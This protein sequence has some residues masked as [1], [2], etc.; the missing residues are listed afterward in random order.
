MPPRTAN[1]TEFNPVL[2]KIFPAALT[3]RPGRREEALRHRIEMLEG[4]LRRKDEVLAHL[5]EELVAPIKSLG[6]I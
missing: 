4:K 6:E 5:M 3:G 1:S 2:W